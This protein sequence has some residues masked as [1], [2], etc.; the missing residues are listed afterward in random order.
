MRLRKAQQDLKQALGRRRRTK[1][2]PSHDK[3]H[4][5]RRIVNDA[6]K[7]IGGWRVLSRDYC[8]AEVGPF[9]PMQCAIMFGPA[10][11]TGSFQCLRDVDP[12]AMR[13]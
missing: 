10:G 11:K 3:V 5:R 12:P 2:L 4:A 9:T 13:R 7:V 6:G 8:I 1:I